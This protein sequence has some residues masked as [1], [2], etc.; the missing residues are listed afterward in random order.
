M[1]FGTARV[2]RRRFIVKLTKYKETNVRHKIARHGR[3]LTTLAACAAFAACGGGGGDNSGGRLQTINFTFPGTATL[4][5][6]PVKLTATATSGLPVEFQSATPDVCTVAN[7]AV[8]P[9]KEAQCSIIASQAGGQAADGTVWAPAESVSQAYNVTKGSQTV[10]FPLPDSV[11]LA[12]GAKV[13]LAAKAKNA[14]G[15]D[16]GLPLTYV[17]NTPEVCTLSGTDLVP[18]VKGLCSIT[19]SQAGSSEYLPTQTSS[20]FAVDPW[21][22]IANGFDPATLGAGAGKNASI[23]TKQGGGISVDAWHWSIGNAAIGD[24]GWENCSSQLGDWCYQEIPADGSAM[25]SALHTPQTANAGWDNSS[26]YNRVDIFGPGLTALA[27]NADTSGGQQV[28]NETALLL[29][30]E[31]PLGQVITKKPIHLQL[32]LSKSNGDGC[33]VTL[34]APLFPTGPGM[35]RYAIPLNWFATTEACGTGASA[36][37]L[38]AVRGLPHLPTMP[39]AFLDELDK[40]SMK[41]ARTS[42]GNL[43]KTYPTVQLRIRN[44]SLQFIMWTLDGKQRP[45]F[46]NDLK[47]GGFIVLI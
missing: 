26:A 18:K 6:G 25:T 43:L 32:V 45:V 47:V 19:A 27:A 33:N 42:A 28:T 21:L 31:V 3:K 30:L 29:N 46:N 15:A 8:T 12:G 23:R 4:G 41:A 39:D 20:A 24:G 2:A 17:V 38:D 16:T 22:Y 36:V 1:T 14:L 34:S 5:L 10:D 44:H 9:L 40:D 35:R 13:P 37:S 7:G 11:Q